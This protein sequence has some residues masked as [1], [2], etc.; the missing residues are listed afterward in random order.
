MRSRPPL[1]GTSPLLLAP[2]TEQDYDMFLPLEETPGARR[3]PYFSDYRFSLAQDRRTRMEILYASASDITLNI[4]LHGEY[5]AC[6]VRLPST[7]GNNAPFLQWGRLADLTL[8][9]GNHILRLEGEE[10][11]VYSSLRFCDIKPEGAGGVET[12]GATAVPEE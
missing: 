4:A 7:G 1:V 2:K 5:V 10:L 12:G 9:R 8:K 6:G 3:P 11:P